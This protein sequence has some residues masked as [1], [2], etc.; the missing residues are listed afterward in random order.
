MEKLNGLHNSQ[1]LTNK[2][3]LNDVYRA[4]NDAVAE[5]PPEFRRVMQGMDQTNIIPTRTRRRVTFAAQ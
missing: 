5:P 2:M 3:T 4:F 1:A